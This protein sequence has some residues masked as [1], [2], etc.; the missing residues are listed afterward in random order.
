MVQL[1]LIN[2][3][4]TGIWGV[5][6]SH[7]FSDDP[8]T[9]NAIKAKGRKTIEESLSGPGLNRARCW[10]CSSRSPGSRRCGHSAAASFRRRR[11]WRDGGLDRRRRAARGPAG[12][13]HQPGGERLVRPPR[14]RDQR[15]GPAD[16]LRP[17]AR[18][19]G[20][21]HCLSLDLLSLAVAAALGDRASPPRSLA[22]RSPGPIA[23]RRCGSRK[24][25]GGATRRAAPAT[26]ACPG[27]RARPSPAAAR[28][29]A[30]VLLAAALQRRCPRHHD[31]QRLQI[32]RGRSADGRAL[33]ARAARRRPRRRASPA[34]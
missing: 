23:R 26:R 14:G 5:R 4:R 29:S 30:G 8:Q 22:S 12:L 13:R 21:R 10:N 1:A 3:A 25:A 31:A 28:R 34:W 16:S 20:L 6:R 11:R 24:T 15:A 7:R 18:G 19:L 9:Y 32:R 2:G 33:A 17:G 27:S